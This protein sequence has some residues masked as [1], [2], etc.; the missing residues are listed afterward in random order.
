MMNFMKHTKLFIYNNLQQLKRKSFILPLILLFPVILIGA[1][2]ILLLAFVQPVDQAPIQLGVVNLDQSSETEMIIDVLQEASEFGPFLEIETIDKASAESKIAANDLS[3][4]ILLPADFTANLYAGNPVTMSV[5]GNPAQQM[6]SNVV[7][8][9]INSVM[10][11]IET[12]QANILLVNEYAQK[13]DMPDHIRSDLVMDEFMRT[14]LSIAG[15]DKIISEQT[16]NHY[17]STSPLEY[18]VLS[19]FFIVLTI[20]LLVMYH[21]LYREETDR[22]K[23]R[24]TLYGVS[25]LQQIVARIVVT[26]LTVTLFATIAFLGMTLYLSFELYMEDYFRIALICLLY[27]LTFLHVLALGEIIISS[28]SIRLLVHTTITMLL[29]GLSG[30]LIPAIYFPLGIQDMLVYIPSFDALFWLQEILLQDR[31]YADLN[32]LLLYSA[33]SMLLLIGLSIWKERGLR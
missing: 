27:S 12:S 20:W 29:I 16:I 31:L 15:K 3:A 25:H 32:G 21:F 11:H 24:M 8:E 2:I 19:S 13:V 1:I 4:F 23:V 10:R 33:G 7:H 9:L 22:L 6:E 18:F 14:F 30:A 17:S 28:P 26:V 5:T